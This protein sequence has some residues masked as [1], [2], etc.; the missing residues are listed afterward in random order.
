[1]KYTEKLGLKKPEYS[2]PADISVLNDNFDIIDKNFVGGAVETNGV[3]VH[4]LV[5]SKGAISGII[6][7]N[8]GE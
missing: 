7:E 5:G 3:A 4:I 6:P 8:Q 2:D 1:M